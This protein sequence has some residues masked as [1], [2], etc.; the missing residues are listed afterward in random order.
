M[1]PNSI[2]AAPAASLKPSI[3]AEEP[4]SCRLAGHVHVGVA[5]VASSVRKHWQ[6]ARQHRARRRRR[7]IPP[8]NRAVWGVWRPSGGLG[9][10][11][12]GACAGT[13]KCRNLRVSRHGRP[14][15]TTMSPAAAGSGCSGARQTGYRRFRRDR[16][17]C[18][19]E[20]ACRMEHENQQKCGTSCVL[21]AT[22]PRQ[23]RSHQSDTGRRAIQKC[24]TGMPG[25]RKRPA[26]GW[27]R[28][29]SLARPIDGNLPAA[30][31]QIDG[32]RR[33]ATRPRQRW[34]AA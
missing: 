6:E 21:V 20:Q 19:P 24:L 28:R 11:R 7:R 18:K 31:T 2:A 22:T 1:R 27:A 25:R 5:S 3:D 34:H 26:P 4:N 13:Q 15:L 8:Q 10:A 17:G 9:R 16:S 32:A 29:A 23:R 30:K 33:P 12:P 14:K